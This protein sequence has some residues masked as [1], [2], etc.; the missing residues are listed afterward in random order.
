MKKAKRSKTPYNLRKTPEVSYQV[1]MH[2]RLYDYSDKQ[3]LKRKE[4]R[5]SYPPQ[6]VY[7]PET[8]C[9]FRI[10]KGQKQ[11]L[12]KWKGYSMSQNTWEPLKN[13]KS[14]EKFIKA[15]DEELARLQFGVSTPQKERHESGGSGKGLNDYQL[16]L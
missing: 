16:I 12:I 13:L 7:Y 9:D 14:I 5:I 6:E 11:Y 15:Y 4:A 3:F 10:E 1:R 2:S 8:I